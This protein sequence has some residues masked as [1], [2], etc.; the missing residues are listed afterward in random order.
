[1]LLYVE[2]VVFFVFLKGFKE[3]VVLNLY[4]LSFSLQSLGF[5]FS[6]LFNKLLNLVD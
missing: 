1:M 4:L 6:Y 3:E 5:L 2:L